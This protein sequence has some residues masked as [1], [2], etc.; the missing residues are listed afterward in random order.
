MRR[1]NIYRLPHPPSRARMDHRKD[2]YMFDIYD[3]LSRC[4]FSRVDPGYQG[5][6]R[7]STD[8][9]IALA[10]QY[11]FEWQLTRQCG[12]NVVPTVELTST[13]APYV[14]YITWKLEDL[15]L[16]KWLYLPDLQSRHQSAECWVYLVDANLILVYH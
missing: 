8:E 9:L 2:V 12:F 7:L 15:P 6:T 1:N 16:D 4:N 11:F 13:I 3:E 10:W 5:F 14:K